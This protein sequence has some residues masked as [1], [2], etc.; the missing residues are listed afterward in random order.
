MIPALRGKV[1]ANKSPAV[2][3]EPA[4]WPQHQGKSCRQGLKYF[5]PLQRQG[6]ASEKET[7][8]E[9]IYRIAATT[10]PDSFVD[11]ADF[12]KHVWL[13]VECERLM[14]ENNRL[15]HEAFNRDREIIRLLARLNSAE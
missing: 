7:R 5:T 11:P 13:L 9:E 4:P 14:V 10:S 15:F 2:E 6:G 12:E 8:M 1:T 3:C